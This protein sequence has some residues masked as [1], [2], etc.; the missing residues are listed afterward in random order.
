MKKVLKFYVSP[1]LADHQ[2]IS[3]P[4]N[5][6]LVLKRSPSRPVLKARP[7]RALGCLLDLALLCVEELVEEEEE[8]VMLGVEVTA[9]K[10]EKAF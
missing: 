5:S 7:S 9:E 6:S 4:S 10:V 8:E 3:G 2:Y 1:S